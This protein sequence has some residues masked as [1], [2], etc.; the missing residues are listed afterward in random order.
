MDLVITIL[1][2]IGMIGVLIGI[3]AWVRALKI[4]DNTGEEQMSRIAIDFLWPAMIVSSM[5]SQLHREDIIAN[6]TLPLFAILTT[7]TGFGVG[8][9]FARAGKLDGDRKAMFLYHST[10]NN[11]IFMALPFVNLFVPQKGQA[12][13]FIHNLGIIFG[14]WTIGVGIFI[15]QNS[16]RDILR[17]L[18]TPGFVTTII[19]I[20]IVLSGVNEY[21][22]AFIVES[23]NVLGNASFAVSML[24]TGAQ[25]YKLGK[26]ALRFDRWNIGLVSVRLIIVP[27]L[28]S[29]IAWICYKYYHVPRDIILVFSIVNFMPASLNSVSMALRFKSSPELAAQGIVSTTVASSVTILI[30]LILMK[31]V[32]GG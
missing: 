2:K 24:I 26:G 25:I 4:I 3:G 14:I 28:L 18:M 29:V 27:V 15:K 6:W 10:I 30:S 32:F 11:F 23:S 31:Q 5:V 8:L 1:Q 17:N 7:V 16:L 12:L 20:G 9:L 13:L 22:P 19:T 21:L